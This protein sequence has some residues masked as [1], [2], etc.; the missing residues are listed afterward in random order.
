VPLWC[1]ACCARAR[2]A[3]L[4]R[5]M[6][7]GGEGG[8]VRHKTS[9]RLLWLRAAVQRGGR[10]QTGSVGRDVWSVERVWGASGRC[11]LAGGA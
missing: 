2:A 3:L 5:P 10:G 9:D 11:A 4:A 8:E 6:R 1:E 7:R